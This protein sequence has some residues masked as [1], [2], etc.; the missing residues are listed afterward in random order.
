MVKPPIGI[1]PSWYVLSD[2]IK[3]IADGISRYTEHERICIDNDV[4]DLIKEWSME[5]ICH[6]NTIQELNDF[7]KKE[8]EHDGE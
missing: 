4:T 1:R 5:I 7:R 8:N 6:C 3:E 2:R